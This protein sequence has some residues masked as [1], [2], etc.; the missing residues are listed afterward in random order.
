MQLSAR[1]ASLVLAAALFALGGACA[2]RPPPAATKVSESTGA[3][4][5]VAPPPA[6]AA[7]VLE[8][9]VAIGDIHGDL[10]AARRAL[11][12]AGAIDERDAWVGGKLV[13]VQTG[14]Q[15]DRGKEDREVLDLFEKLKGEASRA[16]GRMLSLSGNHELM[17]A[18]FDFR[19]VVPEAYPAFAGFTP[20]GPM[21]SRAARYGEEKRGRASAFAP[22]GVYALMLAERPVIA[23][24]GDSVFAHGG[25]HRKHVDYG[26]DRI[27]D[28]VKEWLAGRASEPPAIAVAEDGPV[29][30]RAYSSGSVTAE[31]CRNLGEVLAKLGRKRLVMGHTVQEGGATSACDGK[32][33]R[34]DV[35]MSE[36][37]GG[38]TEVLEI[39][40]GEAR[41][42]RA[43]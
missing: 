41:V 16:G 21:A 33:W 1:R 8:R 15:I 43:P 12:T 19:Y 35:G 6:P 34:V 37:Y 5:P 22:G 38:P 25:V 36:H 17:N 11:R 14:D 30:T 24:V 3:K 18:S 31:A 26:I 2:E 39:K 9:V 29:W 28:G 40:G 4:A 32:A 27:N 10:R 13:V 23:L 7:E 42:L 20:T